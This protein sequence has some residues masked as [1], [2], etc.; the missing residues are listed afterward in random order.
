MHVAVLRLLF[1]TVFVAKLKDFVNY[2]LLRIVFENRQLQVLLDSEVLVSELVEYI[3]VAH[4]SLLFIFK[5]LRQARL[6]LVGHLFWFVQHI[7]VLFSQVVDLLLEDLIGP[8][9]LEFFALLLQFPVL[10]D[11]DGLLLI[12]L[13]GGLRF[14]LF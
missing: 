13:N 4:L 3:R 9:L 8:N 7:L 14:K 10:F 2:V 5:H 12:R 1:V 11:F 6:V